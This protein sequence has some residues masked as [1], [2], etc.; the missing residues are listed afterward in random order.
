MVVGRRRAVKAATTAR[1]VGSED[2]QAHG[3]GLTSHHMRIGTVAHTSIESDRARRARPASGLARQLGVK[4]GD[5]SP[6]KTKTRLHN[7]GHLSTVLD[8]GG[9]MPGARP[10]NYFR[11]VRHLISCVW[12]PAH[13]IELYAYNMLHFSDFSPFSTIA[14]RGL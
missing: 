10:R 1:F 9:E 12:W 8:P 2:V 3:A 11:N 7:L 5:D 13:I 6:R 14:Y 4:M